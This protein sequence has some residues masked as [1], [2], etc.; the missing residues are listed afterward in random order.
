[1]GIDFSLLWRNEEYFENRVTEKFLDVWVGP[2][3]E[4]LRCLGFMNPDNTVYNLVSAFM[5]ADNYDRCNH[6]LKKVRDPLKDEAVTEVAI[7]VGNRLSLSG[8]V[9][10]E[11][12][13]C[14]LDKAVKI[15]PTE[16]ILS[17][18]AE[19]YASEFG[20]YYRAYQTALQLKEEYQDKS[21]ARDI[22]D[23]VAFERS[24]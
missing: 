20:D 5:F 1:M 9:P 7:L 10:F 17:L 12:L 19:V 8:I 6:F 24:L 2:E 22:L 18:V 4:D 14:L 13:E 21:L 3:D 15:Y 11:R 23:M 16:D